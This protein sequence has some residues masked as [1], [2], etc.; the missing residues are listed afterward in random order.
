MLT[1]HVATSRP[2]PRLS[3][4]APRSTSKASRP[5]LRLNA[6][7]IRSQRPSMPTPWGSGCNPGN[8]M[9]LALC[10]WITVYY[11]RGPQDDLPTFLDDAVALALRAVLTP[12]GSRFP[13]DCGVGCRL[14]RMVEIW[15]WRERRDRSTLR[16]LHEKRLCGS[17][18][19]NCRSSSSGRSHL[20]LMG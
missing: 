1:L 18:H 3:F 2:A 5:I 11:L 8:D 17:G 19:I 16:R 9:Q 4:L 6:K 10:K 20:V 14:P 15:V 7:T 13:I 12:R